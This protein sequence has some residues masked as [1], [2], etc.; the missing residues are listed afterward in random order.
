MGVSVNEDLAQVLIE[1]RRIAA[2]EIEPIKTDLESAQESLKSL[3]AQVAKITDDLKKPFYKDARFWSGVIAIP[4][5][6]L[7]GWLLKAVWNSPALLREIHRAFGT[8]PALIAALGEDDNK[9]RKVIEGQLT[10]VFASKGQLEPIVAQEFRRHNGVLHAGIYRVGILPERVR[11]RCTESSGD[12]SNSSVAN[13]NREC[14]IPP[15]ALVTSA[16]SVFGSRSISTVNLD[17]WVHVQEI[18]FHTNGEGHTTRDV[19]SSVDLAKAVSIDLDG[20]EVLDMRRERWLREYSAGGEKQRLVHLRR[21]QHKFEDSY[22]PD[23]HLRE[24]TI[25]MAENLASKYV[26][27][28][29]VVVSLPSS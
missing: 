3:G 20:K 23:F 16:S 11:G 24:L 6:V 2:A 26:I 28:L 27:T 4:S 17:V 29:I 12:A 21:S 19:T 13:K 25:Q 18:D 7:T 22:V 15:D 5:L 1:S 10:N 8:E 14:K 9:L